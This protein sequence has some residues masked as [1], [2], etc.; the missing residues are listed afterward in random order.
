MA[1]ARR[2]SR[3]DSSGSRRKAEKTSSGSSKGTFVILPSTLQICST[4]TVT[5]IYLD[6]QLIHKIK[7]QLWPHILHPSKLI[8]LV[9]EKRYLVSLPVIT[10]IQPYAKAYPADVGQDIELV[11]SFR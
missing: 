5:L 8:R 7:G 2:I 9:F 4:L 3:T 10:V 11:A 1:A 6:N